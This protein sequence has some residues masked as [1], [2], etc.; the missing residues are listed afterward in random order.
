MDRTALAEIYGL[1]F[2]SKGDASG[3]RESLRVIS[4][5]PW[6]KGAEFYEIYQSDATTSHKLS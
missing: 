4:R 6:G 2:V 3:G 1:H 5:P